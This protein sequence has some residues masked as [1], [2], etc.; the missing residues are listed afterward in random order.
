[1]VGAWAVVWLA[2]CGRSEPQWANV[3]PAEVV[4]RLDG[5]GRT[6]LQLKEGS[7]GFWVS[8]PPLDAHPGDAVLLGKGPKKHR[9]VSADLHRT[10]QDMLIVEEAKIATPEEI[11]GYAQLDPAPGGITVA[12]AFARSHELN[13]Q[14]VK[15][16]GRVVKVN[17]NIFGRNWVHLR[18]GTGAEGT[19]DLTVTSTAMA[20]AGQIVVVEGTLT[21]DK[22]LGFGYQYPAIVEEAS[23]TPE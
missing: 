19:D 17:E 6:C 22:N 7:F 13:G 4:E 12:D 8:V 3:A 20:R 9:Y 2:A 1:V 10:F 23:I 14:P 18:D 5:D 15:V 16:R 11:A 21:A